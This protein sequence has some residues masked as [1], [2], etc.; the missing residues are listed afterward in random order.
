M[1]HIIPLESR[2]AWHI[3]LWGLEKEWKYINCDAWQ[4]GSTVMSLFLK[5]I[6][7]DF[8]LASNGVRYEGI[9]L[10]VLAYD[11]CFFF[12]SMTRILNTS[13]TFHTMPSPVYLV[14]TTTQISQ[15]TRQKPESCLRTFC[16]HRYEQVVW[17]FLVYIGSL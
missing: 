14:C 5:L 15:R 13:T 6:K 9:L 7:P 1:I 17:L 10:F 11:F 8:L 2:C 3:I 4:R 12:C 16:W